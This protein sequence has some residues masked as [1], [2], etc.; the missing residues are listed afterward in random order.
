MLVLMRHGQASFGAAHYDR[1]SALGI[2]QA[3]AT[4]EHFRLRGARHAEVCVGPR[5]RHRHTARTLLEHWGATPPQRD[6][7]ELDEFADSGEIVAATGRE[8]AGRSDMERMLIGIEGWAAGRL[9]IPGRPSFGEFRAA[10]A[11]WL[12]RELREVSAGSPTRLVVSSAGVVAAAVC[13]AMRLPDASFVP[14]ACRI[15]NASLT[16]ITASRG[17]P[18]IVS[19]NGCGHLPAALLTAI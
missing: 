19:F 2:A 18:A 7:A 11:A 9:E 16:E 17:R 12:A 8:H 1:L 13:E 15:R 5:E 10:V 4:G 6:L 3:A 14:L